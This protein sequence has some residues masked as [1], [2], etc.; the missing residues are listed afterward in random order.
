MDMKRFSTPE[1]SKNLE[2]PAAW[3]CL[4]S[5]VLVLPGLG[6]ITAGFRIRGVLQ[7]IMSLAGM[8]ITLAWFAWFFTEYYRTR[9]LEEALQ[10]RLWVGCVGVGIFMLSWTWALATSLGIIMRVYSSDKKD[11]PPR[12]PTE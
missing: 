7:I 5:N 8:G 3:A 6:T 4:L 11:V 10:V 2:R 9:E 12:I 1:P